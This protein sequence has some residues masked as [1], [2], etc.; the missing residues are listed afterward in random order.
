MSTTP[1]AD[2]P[3]LQTTNSKAFAYTSTSLRYAVTHVFLPV[4]LPDKNDYTPENDHSL[5]RG[6]CAAA[7]AYAT[8]V[9]G[10]SEQARWH[11]ITRMLDNLQVAVQSEHMDN[12]H[13]TSQ[14]WKMQTGDIL[15]FLIRRQNAAIILTKRESCTLCEAFEVSPHRDD[16]K[17][18][19]EPL[20]CSYPGS[21]VETPNEVFDDGAFQ[22]ELTNFLSRPNAV[23][24]DSPLLPS[25]DPQYINALFNGILQSVGRAADVPRATKRTA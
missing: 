1:T 6:V 5:A 19:P 7:H 12:D 23:D 10:T 21:A 9:C 2:D 20:I 22:S 18:T 17:N 24:S 11:R 13:V 15:A 4:Q 16:I 3:N 14:L 8:H 25:A